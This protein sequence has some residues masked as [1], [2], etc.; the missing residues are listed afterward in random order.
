MHLHHAAG[1]Q[2]VHA[3]GNLGASVRVHVAGHRLGHNV[4]GGGA[5]VF[6]VCIEAVVF[7]PDVIVQILALDQNLLQNGVIILRTL[8]HDLLAQILSL[9]LQEG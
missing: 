3:H 4:G 2:T 5:A 6:Y 8:R 7:Q 1:S 9:A